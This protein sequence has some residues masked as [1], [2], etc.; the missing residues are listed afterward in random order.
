MGVIE[1]VNAMVAR[2]LSETLIKNVY[3][4]AHETLRENWSGSIQAKVGGAWIQEM[5]QGWQFRENVIARAGLSNSERAQLQATLAG[6]VQNL[7]MLKEK[8]SLLYSDNKLH[9]ALTDQL[10]HAGVVN[11]DQYYVN[12]Q[13][14]EYQKAKDAATQAAEKAQNEQM[15]LTQAQ[16]Q[17]PL[18]M[19]KIRGT[20]KLQSEQV[21][22]MAAR[23]SQMNEMMA[24]M[25]QF[26]E[27]LELEYDKLKVTQE[28]NVADA[29]AQRIS[30]DG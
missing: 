13:S 9:E 11:P 8:G 14:E 22:A 5:P 18:Q 4:L 10:R 1:Q 30:V 27:K 16:M 12:P 20:A 23:V 26:R 17:V 15:Q 24:E 2:T 3:L 28:K 25:K 21:R 29:N 6:T 19:E 7:S